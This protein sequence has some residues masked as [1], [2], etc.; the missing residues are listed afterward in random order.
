MKS[1]KMV[2]SAGDLVLSIVS[3]PALAFRLGV[4]AIMVDFAQ[5]DYVGAG[6]GATALKYLNPYTM[7]ADA[8]YGTYQMFK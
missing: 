4:T 6:V 2:V 1:I 8:A 5:P 7:G 3:P